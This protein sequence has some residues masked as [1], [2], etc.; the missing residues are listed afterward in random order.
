[1]N[2]RSESKNAPQKVPFDPNVTLNTFRNQELL[3]GIPLFS[4]LSESELVKILDAPENGIE[5][6]AEK[7]LIIEESQ[8]GNCMYV[9]LSGTAEVTVHHEERDIEV[10]VNTLRSGD[11]FGEQAL[12][13]ESDGKRNATVRALHPVTLFRIQKK[14]VLLHVDHKDAEPVNVH[15]TQNLPNSE[16]LNQILNMRLFRTLTED[17]LLRID[18]WTKIIS[19]KPGDF[20]IKESEPAD[21][22]YVILE[23]T[24]EVFTLDNHGKVVILARHGTGRYFGEQALISD[25]MNKRNCYVRSNGHSRLIRIPRDYFRLVLKRDQDLVNALRQVGVAQTQEIE[26]I[27]I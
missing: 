26:K 25:Q 22:M 11:F 20:V 7:Q 21:C 2:T 18:E 3:K 27:K 12:M 6:Y 17:E 13:P 5:E 19:V 15:D 23:G 16:V 1:M 8:I 4:S 9:V 10:T 14:Y 24:L